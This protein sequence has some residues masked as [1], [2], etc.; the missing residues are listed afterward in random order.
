M[1]FMQNRIKPIIH[2]YTAT[3]GELELTFEG[4]QWDDQVL[5]TRVSTH[6]TTMCWI[7]WADKEAFIEDL[8]NAI[9]KYFI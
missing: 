1:N 9:Q 4:E 5:D 7:T 6:G 3:V 8:N 2:T